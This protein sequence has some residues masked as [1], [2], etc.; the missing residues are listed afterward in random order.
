MFDVLKNAV[1]SLNGQS[2]KPANCPN[3]QMEAS[4]DRS[5]DGT[6][7]VLHCPS[8]GMRAYVHPLAFLELMTEENG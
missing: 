2:V 6:M 1:A 8:C 7:V 4:L 5:E 3:H